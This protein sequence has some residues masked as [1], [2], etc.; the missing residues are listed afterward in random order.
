MSKICVAICNYNHER[1][2]EESIKSIIRQDYD[3]LDITV[4]DDGS[5]SKAAREIAGSFLDKRVRFLQLEVNRGK[6][7]A[8]NAAFSTTNAQICTSHDADDV[9]LPWRI[10]SQ[11]FTMKQTETIHNLCGF[12]HCWSEDDV[13]K[14]MIDPKPSSFRIFGREEVFSLVSAGFQTSCGTLGLD[15]TPLIAEL[16]F[17]IAKIQTSTQE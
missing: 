16:E 14:G 15:S 3:D 7:N 1:Y 12:K 17:V 8:L 9:S 11:L 10:S 6:W 13:S 4:V 2:L 5:S